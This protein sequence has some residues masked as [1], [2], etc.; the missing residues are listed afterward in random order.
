[1]YIHMIHGPGKIMLL[2][3]DHSCI[4]YDIDYTQCSVTL[5]FNMKYSL[6]Y[7]VYMYV[8]VHIQS[9]IHHADSATVWLYIGRHHL[10]SRVIGYSASRVCYS[11]N[12]ET[13]LN[14]FSIIIY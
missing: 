10:V 2:Q 3:S 4:Y 5:C 1:M 6:N 14:Y 13:C 11:T 8:H 12:V 9:S 7:L